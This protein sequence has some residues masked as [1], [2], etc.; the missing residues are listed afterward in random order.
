MFPFLRLNLLYRKKR[1]KKRK[2]NGYDV[3]YDRCDS[4]WLRMMNLVV[5]LG[6]LTSRRYGV[7]RVCDLGDESTRSKTHLIMTISHIRNS[8]H[9]IHVKEGVA[10]SQRKPFK[11]SLG[12][13]RRDYSFMPFFT[14]IIQVAHAGHAL[15]AIDRRPSCRFGI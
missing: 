13:E 6:R 1:C 8:F 7:N 12:Q 4:H 14:S 10:Q 3:L 11:A 15:S 5:E 9:V 2:E